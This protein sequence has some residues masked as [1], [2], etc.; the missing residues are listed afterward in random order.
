[1]SRRAALGCAVAALLPGAFGSSARAQPDPVAQDAPS[2]GPAA[3]QSQ[4]RAAPSSFYIAAFDVTGVTILDQ[5]TIE[6]A[7]YDHSGPDR[8]TT[9][10][11]AARKALQD[12]YAQRGYESV[13]VDVMPQ[14][15]ERFAQGIIEITVTEA[16][17]GMVQVAGAKHHSLE[18]VRRQIPSLAEGKPLNV[19][20]LQAELAS[21]NRFPDRSITPSFKAGA[22]PGTVD[23][24]LNV[25]DSLPLHGSIELNNDHSPST[26]P[27]RLN[28]SLRYTNMWGVGHTLSASYIVAP[29]D[30]KQSEVISG[31]Y[32]APLLGSPWT[33]LLYGYKSNSNVA[34]LGGINVLGNGFQAGARA[35]YRLPGDKAM[36]SVTF[37]LDYKNF[38]QNIS[39]S[40]QLVTTTPIEYMALFA[41]YNL[42]LGSDRS[43]LD[44][45]VSVTAGFRVFKK[46][47]CFQIESTSTCIPTDQFKNKDFDSNENFVHANIELDYKRTLPMDF[48][49]A[50][51]FYGQVADSHLVT[52]EQFAIGG[53]ASV[54]GYYQSEAVGDI[55][56]ALSLELSTPSLAPRLPSFVD[57]LR[58]FGFVENGQIRIL[59]P[60]PDVTAHDALLSVGGGARIRL[61]G[62]ISGEFSAGVPLWNGSATRR[63]DVRTLF[64]AKGEF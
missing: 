26:D 29:Q 18:L 3:P 43:T 56:Y 39:L 50:L 22:T 37:G 48:I 15:E 46:I 44:A 59:N 58:L 9:D 21:A 40:D 6:N 12:A 57:E 5:A 19:Q 62:H 36:Q 55:G 49:A 31:S 54:R 45:S 64:S 53:L 7:V 47:D 25:E 10:V 4:V 20:T 33:L 23:V 2:P 35:I 30:R 28:A 24:D 52:N 34:S 41:G 14:P 1:M 51:K 63:H 42:S 32:M 11:E 8:T 61:F 17:V 13:Q 16:P 38:D 27:L 60:A